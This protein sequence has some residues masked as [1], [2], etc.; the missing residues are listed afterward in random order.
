MTKVWLSVYCE[1][2]GV[3]M[4]QHYWVDDFDDE[5]VVY[6]KTPALVPRSEE[7]ESNIESSVQVSSSSKFG[8]FRQSLKQ[9]LPS[10]S[11]QPSGSATGVDQAGCFSF[12]TY[13][14]IFKYLWATFRGKDPNHVQPWA[15][16]VY[17][18]AN[19]NIA[20]LE[21]LWKVESEKT[22]K[23][24]LSRSLYQFIRMRFFF[25]CLCFF[26]CLIFGF[27]GPTCLVRA[28]IQ[29]TQTRWE[30]APIGYGVFLAFA[31]LVVELCR[32]LSYG[33][34]WAIS[35]RTAL[36]ARGA[37]LGFLF[38]RLM[39]QRE[40]NEDSVGEIM[41]IFANDSQRIFDAVSFLPLV[42]VS[43]LVLVGGVIYLLYL[44]GP[45]SLIGLGIFLIFN[46]LQVFIGKRIV[47]LRK[48]A[49]EFTE[50]RIKLINEIL[51]CMRPIKMNALE[52]PFE[53]NVHNV[54][55]DEKQALFK[56]AV[57]QSLAL[58][59]GSV[60]PVVAAASTF[61]IY[62]SLGY[63]LLPDQAY[64]VITVFF[65]MVFGIRMIPYDSL[66]Y[67]QQVHLME[68]ELLPVRNLHVTSSVAL[69]IR[70]GHFLWNI[71]EP[72]DDAKETL[73]HNNGPSTKQFAL[74]DINI[75]IYKKQIVG[76]C[77]PVGC[78]KSSLFLAIIGE[79]IQGNG[80]MQ[81]GGSVA[82]CSQ[83]PWI[84]NATLRENIL[85]GETLNVQLYN[86][87]LRVCNLESDIKTFPA[88]DRTEVRTAFWC[89]CLI[90]G[91]RGATLSGGQKARLSLARAIYHQKDIYLLDNV[92]TA[93]DYNVASRVLKE[94]IQEHLSGKTVLL[95]TSSV[96]FL[97]QCDAILFM[98]QGRIVDFGRHEELLQ[99][100][101]AYLAFCQSTGELKTKADE[102]IDNDD[103]TVI[104]KMDT[105][106]RYCFDEIVKSEQSCARIQDQDQHV[107]EIIAN[108]P[109]KYDKLFESEEN[110]QQK[111]LSMNTYKSYFDA[112]GS[113]RMVL[114][115]LALFALSTGST[116]FSTFWLSYWLKKIHPEFGSSL[117]SSSLSDEQNS[118]SVIS[119]ETMNSFA[120]VYG[121]T[122]PLVILTTVL[123]AYVFV[124][125][126]LRASE[127]LH[128]TMFKRL[129]HGTMR[130]FDITPVGRVI[131]RFSKDIDETD[132][133]IP[134]TL[135]TML[136]N[137]C[138]IFGYLIIIAWVFPWF[139]IAA[140]PLA[141]IFILFIG[142]FRGGI[143]SLKRIENNTRSPL[144]SHISAS[145]RGKSVL[146]PFG[147]TKAFVERMK[148]LLDQ[149][150]CW[151]F[152]FQSAMRWLAVWLDMLVVI[153]VFVISL[154]MIGLAGYIDPAYAGMALTYAL[155]MS[156]IFQFAVR[157]QAEFESKMISVERINYYINNIEQEQL[158]DCQSTLDACWLT[159][160]AVTFKN[161]SLR[162][163][164]DK[165]LA[166]KN[167][168]FD[169]AGG[170]K[171][172]IIGR[173]GSGK[174]SLVSAL[175]R[176]YPI[177]EGTICID[178]HDV[179]LLDLRQL[180][181]KIAVIPQDPVLFSGTLRFNV[182]PQGRCSD[183]QL[184]K[185]IET[186]QL[187]NVVE[188]KMGNG[189]DT[190]IEQGGRN[191][192]VGE[193]QL[194][195]MAR[196]FL[197]NVS[198]FLLDEATAHLDSATDH[199]VQRCFDD[200][201]KKCTVFIIAHRLNSVMACDKI[202][203]LEDGQI[204]EWGYRN[205]LLAMSDSR[206][207]QAVTALGLGVSKDD[208]DD[209]NG[210]VD[211]VDDDVQS[212]SST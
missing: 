211:D 90:V 85:L 21:Y 122:V 39:F 92:L 156:G 71:V 142:C 200:V 112:M 143:R 190:R 181:C 26:F 121:L 146:R 46:V 196:A 22:A 98:D 63:D 159:E 79:M 35:T 124:G 15:C 135:D 108:V 150:S 115:V 207:A 203:Y 176:L 25:A 45:C 201:A 10:R 148:H 119:P 141:G 61:V 113:F 13:S 162:Y 120:I 178:S 198:I 163:G 40:T 100:C 8:Q 147:K 168:S 4:S 110:L 83:D 65:V 139:L 59:L 151:L 171:I 48:I 189:L 183:V 209:E 23:P 74:T 193:R 164:E 136:Q 9:L 28:L 86:T 131:N 19:V 96:Q 62:L 145:V 125:V 204:L 78:G 75:K 138:F 5:D 16:S 36:R 105:C 111:G 73:L 104:E 72:P 56:T 7:D 182:D 93:L 2:F 140:V 116:I 106:Q 84:L 55:K 80:E 154:L 27:I 17:D 67:Y 6:E 172:G 60:M 20:R 102:I 192:S 68:P 144:F 175:L 206:F 152:M 158:S 114:L 50:K 29:F 205:D 174:S 129:M 95:I 191:F 91:E 160:G 66:Y 165:Q 77:G 32:V 118:T 194:V 34:T 202:L 54:R 195:C 30:E 133:K 179:T 149:N 134:F 199:S 117:S 157:M 173:T 101:A 99:R 12:I 43:P 89:T 38:K 126:T 169:V 64:A 14:W 103:G 170:E 33:A 3:A 166:L 57:A 109:I 31:M 37:V 161:V 185:A 210:D 70:D 187:K 18:S 132:T 208:D 76:I 177:C 49:I 94:A 127:H 212:E 24:S 81:V 1:Y 130:W 184:W 53:L 11:S 180:R 128:N 107:K 153:V 197:Q 52:D 97:K 82:Y 51:N 88:G 44:I 123:K 155:Q 87:V 41:N 188:Q 167:V 186:V 42:V 47:F 69:E 58:G 137:L